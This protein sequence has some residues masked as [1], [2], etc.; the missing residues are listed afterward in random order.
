MHKHLKVS[1]E[2]HAK[3]KKEAKAQGM[4]LDEFLIYL[5]KL[6]DHQQQ[7]RELDK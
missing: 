3:V 2:T 4:F 7:L 5:L 1:A 6:H